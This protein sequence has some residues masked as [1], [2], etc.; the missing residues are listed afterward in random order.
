MKFFNFERGDKQNLF[1]DL[2][3]C[4]NRNFSLDR[5]RL[6]LTF[7]RN[8]I[9]AAVL[10]EFFGL[11]RVYSNRGQYYALREFFQCYCPVCSPFKGK[12]VFDV[13]EE[14]L[15]KDIL[16]VR[17]WE[18][19]KE[20]CPSC[21]LSKDD[22]LN[23]GLLSNYNTLLGVVGMRAGKT[24]LAAIIMAFMEMFLIS[25]GNAKEALGLDKAPFVEIA[26]I[27]V[28]AQQAKDTIWAQYR[29]L[30][31]EA[32]WFN[33][34]DRKMMEL[35]YIKSGLYD[36]SLADVIKNEVCGYRVIS[37][38]SSS[39]TVAGRTR[40]L[41][42]I[43]EL[44]RFDT[45]DSK[46]SA[47]EV[48]RA[49]SHSLKTIK[50]A[51]REKGFPF[52]LGSQVAVGSPISVDDYGMKMLNLVRDG[53][54]DSAFAM[55]FATWEFNKEYEMEDFREDFELDFHGSQRDFGADPPGAEVP[56]I[57]DWPLFV[58]LVENKTLNPFV[59]FEDVRRYDGDICYLGKRISQIVVV[60]GEW[61]IAGDAGR[62]KD[63]FA[64]VGCRR[65]WRD[66]GDF[67]FEQ[68]FAMHIL[69]D[70]S[71]RVY[72]D[73][74]CIIGLIEELCRMLSVQ[75]ISFDYWQSELMVQDLKRKGFPVEQ[76][77][78]SALRV[79][80]F[81]EFRRAAL[82]GR[83]RLLP[84]FGSEDTDPRL[85][86]SQTR[87]YWELKRLRRSKDLK[88]IDHGIN[89]TSDL[90]ESLVN[91]YRLASTVGLDTG[92][93]KGKASTQLGRIVRMTRW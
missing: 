5:N 90:A 81:F 53:D 59:R 80:D 7:P 46:R 68:G 85:M 66:D 12:Q 9:E 14:D 86:D 24:M 47:S 51:A 82:S 4:I 77:S 65:L 18:E 74:T 19:G 17:N 58:K 91:S 92:F 56:F 32:E 8:V 42:V 43:D 83:V 73:F 10:K 38:S 35:G 22:F 63:S 29:K 57:E 61:F 87:Q 88:K 1:R 15:L 67:D 40:V 70:A 76:Y 45:T 48:W 89:S 28:S 3:D 79:D 26:C 50:K 23:E 55:K 64:L 31:A 25:M 72:V 78:M 39:A 37:L 41:F 16:L 69:P 6:K 27:A 54:I 60:P 52:W 30:R 13:S 20:Y 33:V 71:K 36:T 49:G 34:L 62:S 2:E 75:R 84:R 11:E 44:G 21:G 93:S